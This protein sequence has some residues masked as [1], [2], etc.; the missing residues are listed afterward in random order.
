MAVGEVDLLACEEKRGVDGCAVGVGL[1]GVVDLG[2]Y[3][4]E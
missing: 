3:G 2:E 1:A 4:A